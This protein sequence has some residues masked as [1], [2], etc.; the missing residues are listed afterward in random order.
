[1]Q[2]L[3]AAAPVCKERQIF[4]YGCSVWDFLVTAKPLC[5][6]IF[7][8]MS[9]I[10][11]EH[12]PSIKWTSFNGLLAPS[13]IQGACHL[14]C[15]EPILLCLRVMLHGFFVPLV[16]SRSNEM[17]RCIHRHPRV[18]CCDNPL[19]TRSLSCSPF[20][21]PC[22][23]CTASLQMQLFSCTASSQMRC[24][25]GGL[26]S[27]SMPRLSQQTCS[28]YQSLSTHGSNLGGVCLLCHCC[29][30]LDCRMSALDAR[31]IVL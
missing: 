30:P 6:R 15:H 4:R 25:S 18:P 20:P 1:M 16:I 9:P 22:F 7:S 12:L 3:Y 8:R 21:L 26:D 11:L 17:T 29:C 23:C 19:P 31:C 24:V 27:F 28:A 2:S 5:Q 14:G 10:F 13:K